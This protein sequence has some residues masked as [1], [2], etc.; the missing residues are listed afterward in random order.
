MSGDVEELC[1]PQHQCAHR[2]LAVADEHG[3]RAQPRRGYWQGRQ[4]ERVARFEGAVYRV[5]ERLAE[6]ARSDVVLTEHVP[7]HFEPHPDPRRV[8]RGVLLEER[9]V[10]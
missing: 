8:A 6:A 2:L 5:P 4:Q 9:R 7:T 1:E 10:I 3:R